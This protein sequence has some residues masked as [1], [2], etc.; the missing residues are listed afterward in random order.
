MWHCASESEALLLAFPGIFSAQLFS[1]SLWPDWVV[2][3]G[4]ALFPCVL[5]SRLAA[6]PLTDRRSAKRGRGVAEWEIRPR[7]SEMLAK[8][9]HR[10]AEIPGA[11]YYFTWISIERKLATSKT[12]CTCGCS[13]TKEFENTVTWHSTLGEINQCIVWP[14]WLKY[15]T[16]INMKTR[17]QRAYF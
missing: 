14:L 15:S 5:W 6:K 13:T 10:A 8:Y 3:D 17:S 9:G 16:K 12:S 4:L 1:D 11:E 2:S 7:V